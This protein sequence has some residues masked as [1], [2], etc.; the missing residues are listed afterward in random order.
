[1]ALMLGLRKS[2]GQVQLV[3]ASATAV[4]RRQAATALALATDGSE[5]A[6]LATGVEAREG[7]STVVTASRESDCPQIYRMR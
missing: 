3:R 1:M 4:L 5:A 2:S 6:P 7:A